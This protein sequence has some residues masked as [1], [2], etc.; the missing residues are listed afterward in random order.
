MVEAYARLLR[1]QIHSQTQYRL[2]FGVDVATAALST[3]VEAVVVF[4]LFR[5][6]PTVGGFGLRE[7]LLMSALAM[8]AFDL[9][10]L[11]VG[12]VERLSFYVRKGLL[13]TV[14]VRPLGALPQLLVTDF[15]L[16]R[17]GRVAQ[18]G[19]LLVAV[20]V[21]ADL[22]W[23]PARA[24][25][26]VLTPIAGCALFMA[27]FVLGACVAFWFVESGEIA[28]AFTYGGKEFARY[29]ATI[30]P[31]L[32][33]RVF[34]YGFGL[35]LVAYQ[36]ALFLTGHA[37]PLGGPGWL[38]WLSPLVAAFAW[39]IALLVWRTGIRHYRSTGS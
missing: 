13:D 30:Y 22:D 33:R 21:Y 16:R 29:P 3:L 9:A 5:V 26:L 31:G 20:L 39:M 17:I 2:S 14:L 23:T 12:N 7:V 28:N 4:V 18:S 24:L 15:A 25:M 27:V 11:L 6:T 36:P 37:D 8:F 34:G 19:V 1:A 10:D 32:L 35:A 38:A